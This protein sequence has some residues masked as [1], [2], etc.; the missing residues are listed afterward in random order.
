MKDSARKD[1]SA[2][3]YG[4]LV[5]MMTHVLV[6]VFTRIHPTLFPL[7]RIEF[8]LSLTQLGVI[9][10]IPRL[11]GSLLSLPSGWLSDR[12]GSKLMILVSLC[13]SCLGIL[14]AS[15]THNY[16]TLILAISLVSINITIYHP[17]SYRL[18]TRL[19]ARARSS[20]LA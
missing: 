19:Q 10:S 18:I 4:P 8:G 5:T 2:L 13:I 17:A 16:A 3:S 11:F 6:H 20:S 14:I 9:A 15:Q 12:F 1:D 7:L